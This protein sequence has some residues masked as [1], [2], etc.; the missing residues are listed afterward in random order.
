MDNISFFDWIYLP[1]SYTITAADFFVLLVVSAISRC[2]PIVVVVAD[3]ADC[4]VIGLVGYNQWFGFLDGSGGLY[5]PG[6]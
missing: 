4:D 3:F 1:Y 2:E 5:D 6:A